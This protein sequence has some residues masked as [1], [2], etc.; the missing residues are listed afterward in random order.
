MA[1]SAGTLEQLILESREL[2]PAAPVSGNWTGSNPASI[3]RWA[4]AVSGDLLRVRDVLEGE[5]LELID[6]LLAEPTVRARF[7]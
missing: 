5:N 6:R 3:G 2:V 7:G 4:D 1:D